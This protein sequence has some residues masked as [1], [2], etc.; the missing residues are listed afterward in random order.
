MNQATNA[1]RTAEHLARESY[2]RLLALL[3]PRARDISGAEDALADAL[4][5]ALRQWP[6]QGV[7]ANPEA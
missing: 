7:P 2:G 5:A 6:E 1:Q 3:A 4:V